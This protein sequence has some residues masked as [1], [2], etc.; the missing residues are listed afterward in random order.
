MYSAR[1]T[2]FTFGKG[3]SA[4]T[5]GNSEK[6]SNCLEAARAEGFVCSRGIEGLKM[7]QD[8]LRQVGPDLAVPWRIHSTKAVERRSAS[9]HTQVHLFVDLR[10]WQQTRRRNKVNSGM[11]PSPSAL[12]SDPSQDCD[13]ESS[14]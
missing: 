14:W 7:T 4:V 11:W 10:P 5:D 9:G 12:R 8:H 3:L 6:S 2:T 13:F 1:A